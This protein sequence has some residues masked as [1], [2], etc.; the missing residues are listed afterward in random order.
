M[1][2]P[3]PRPRWLT[4][5][6][7]LL[8][9]L[10]FALRLR[11]A[12]SGRWAWLDEAAVGNFLYYNDFLSIPVAGGFR[13]VQPVAYS[14]F[15]KL[16]AEAFGTYREWTL[17]L[18]AMISGLLTLGGTA[19]LS[20]R[21]LGP[22]GAVTATGL[23][24][25]SPV[26]ICYSWEIKPYSTDATVALAILAIGLLPSG[27]GLTR[28]LPRAILVAALA[29][30]ASLPSV[31]ALPGLLMD[32]FLRDPKWRDR[33]VLGLLALLAISAFF[34]LWWAIKVKRD[35]GSFL[36]GFWSQG[37]PPYSDGVGAV[38]FWVGQ[39]IYEFPRYVLGLDLAWP[40]A[41][42]LGLVGAFAS[43][44]SDQRLLRL[45]GGTIV[46]ACAAA[47]LKVYPLGTGSW[48]RIN[49]LCLYLIPPLAFLVAGG[50]DA[51]ARSHDRRR[52]AL[53]V[54]ILLGAAGWSATEPGD[55]PNNQ[56]ALQHIFEEAQ[57]GDVVGLDPSCMVMW[58]YHVRSGRFAARENQLVRV[59]AGTWMGM[60]EKLPELPPGTRRIWWLQTLDGACQFK[61]WETFLE[62]HFELA[63]AQ[64]SEKGLSL[65]VQP[66]AARE[67]PPPP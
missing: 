53:A 52:V 63:P 12:S 44:R 5:V 62:E 6:I 41:P 55:A 27:V 8:L 66:R 32:A 16:C 50:V 43:W 47:A 18:P 38:V 28:P 24:A 25:L 7:T 64:P 29:P 59:Q 39:K 4:P 21:V 42:I 36:N 51:L 58:G 37:Y 1:S 57:G 10:G 65:W 15:A 45:A 49:R 33:L 22:W 34:N 9:V 14:W 19:W 2:T 40:L 20:R 61:A 17:R 54:A 67:N 26:L 30:W 60:E 11:E 31:F 56:A 48:L 3:S 35:M 13:M 46:M 23:V